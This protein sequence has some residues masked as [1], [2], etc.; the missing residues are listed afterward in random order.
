MG[1]L[2]NILNKWKNENK[3]S[4]NDDLYRCDLIGKTGIRLVEELLEVVGYYKEKSAELIKK[5]NIKD[6]TLN[7]IYLIDFHENKIEVDAYN[8]FRKKHIES[9][10]RFNIV[11]RFDY[12]SSGI[13]INL[14]VKCNVCGKEEDL[15]DYG[16]W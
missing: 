4:C 6:W 15:T 9:C 1:K 12:S 3:V 14:Y 10:R 8:K 5:E 7:D 16:V 13:G 2:K 11:H